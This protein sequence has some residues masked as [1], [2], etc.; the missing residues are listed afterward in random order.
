MQSFLEEVVAQIRVKHTSLE[1][2]VFIL[3][4]KR[5]GTFLRKALAETTTSTAFAPEIHSIESFVEHISKIEY[6]SN[7]EQL[8]E[9]YRVYEQFTKGEKDSFYAFS[10]WGQTLVQDF[11]ELDRYLID[12]PQLF[13]NLSAIQEIGAWS[14]GV[15]RTQMMQNYVSFWKNIQVLYKNFNAALLEKG[16]G[17]QGLVYRTAHAKLDEYI[18]ETANKVHVFI[19][20]NALNTAEEEL[21]QSILQQPST[22]IYWDVDS[23]YL[24]DPEHDAGYFIRKHVK[25]WPFFQNNSLQGSSSHFTS[26]KQIQIVGVPKSVSQAKY[27]GHLL[28]EL[29]AANPEQLKNTAV[30]LGDEALLNP[31]LNSIP[32]QISNVNITMGYPLAK[33]NLAS[34]FTQF[35]NLYITPDT[36]GW[37][38]QV[39]LDFLA[40]PHIQIL[41]EE[42]EKNAALSLIEK[43]KKNNWAFLSVEK[44]QEASH[45]HELVPL[46]FFQT[47]LSPKALVQKCLDLILVLKEKLQANNDSLSLEQLF[48]FHQLFTQLQKL[49][50]QHAFIKDMKSLIGLFKE[51]LS[52][53]TLDFQGE[54]LEGLQLMGMLESRNLDFETVIL[55]SVNEGILPSG[56]SNNSFIPFDLKKAFKLPTYKEKDAVYTYHFYRLLQRA[57]NIY[58]IY[59]TEPDALEGG[60]KSRLIHQLLTDPKIRPQITE[61][62]AAPSLAPVHKELEEI[63]KDADLMKRIKAHAASGFSPTSLSN[64]IRNPIDFYTRNLLDIDEVSEVEETVAYNT[65]GTIVHDSLESLYAPFVGQVLNEEKLL[66]A[67]K[68]IVATVE[69]HFKKSYADGDISRGK[70]L[71]AFH[72][73]QQYIEKFIAMEITETK[74]HEIKILAL[75]ENLRVTLS[76]PELDFPVVLKGKLDR[77]DTKDGVL[78][79]IDYKTGKVEAKH[80]ELVQWEELSSNYDFN[81]A[82]QLLC[83]A[84]MYSK[85]APISALRAGIFSFKNLNSG[86]LSFATKDRMGRGAIKVQEITSETLDHFK[87]ELHRLI[88]EI[89]NPAEPLREKE[90]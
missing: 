56:K 64:Y 50:E 69:S 14:P 41:F 44:I 73:V 32:E 16:I 76:M 38:Y 83:Y 33:S 10:K 5:A 80:V 34:F 3:P 45:E 1:Q 12:S 75:E 18:K 67:K 30:V 8:F 27:V 31:I 57:K 70:N 46:V 90:V 43:I 53:E 52:S 59:N 29:Q 23:Y 48:R 60:E 15:E 2:L 13:S 36:Q 6:A 62:I 11:N 21:I 74:N 22:E 72:V 68:K 78:R 82:F 79:I 49:L 63:E 26:A 24:D 35:L 40:N 65:L 9:L 89:A 20:F 85:T 61:L 87:K 28:A 66:S 81:K 86:F 25:N 19:G 58:L 55:S 77:V 4:S 42:G 54:P 84:F 71:I 37:F 39:V 51:L 17:H 7:T 47:K 88:L